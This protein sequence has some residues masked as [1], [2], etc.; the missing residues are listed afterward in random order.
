MN[1]I[2][3]NNL[4]YQSV[5]HPKMFAFKLWFDKA[6]RLWVS[7]ALTMSFPML[8][9]AQG[10]DSIWVFLFVMASFIWLVFPMVWNSDKWISN[11]FDTEIENAINNEYVMKLRKDVEYKSQACRKW[12]NKAR[13][14][15]RVLRAQ[16]L[17]SDAKK[18]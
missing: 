17:G 8:Y 11:R 16:N 6:C 12:K 7:C 4:V 13:T 18:I 10:G 9:A 14:L 1:N 15:H 5:I 3:N 2:P